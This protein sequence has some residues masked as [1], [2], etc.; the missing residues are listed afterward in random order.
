[1]SAVHRRIGRRVRRMQRAFPWAQIRIDVSPKGP[2]PAATPA[3]A[4]RA[5]RRQLLHQGSAP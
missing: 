4:P 3:S 1:M 2:W 5:R